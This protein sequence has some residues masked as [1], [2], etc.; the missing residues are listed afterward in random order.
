[1]RIADVARFSSDPAFLVLRNRRDTLNDRIDVNR[2]ALVTLPQGVPGGDA[3]RAELTTQLEGGAREL[4][5]VEDQLLLRYPRFMELT[6]PRPVT[7]EDLQQKLL[8][9][10]EALLTYV[11]LPQETVIFAVTR[12]RFK[13]VSSGVRRDDL[14]RRIHGIRRSIEK[15][16]SGDSVLFLRE[17]DPATLHSLH[18][19]LIDP[20]SDLLAGVEKVIVVGDGPLHTIPLEFFVTR[21][22]PAEQQA[23]RNARSAADGSNAHPYLGEYKL[24]EYLGKQFRFAYLPSL[25]A[26]TSQRLYPKATG[27]RSREFIAFADPDF[28]PVQGSDKQFSASTKVSLAAL[29]SSVPRLRDGT[30]A[31]PRL[32][33]TADEAREIAKLLGG[34]SE[35][36]IGSNAQEKTAKLGELKTARF[37]LFATHGFLG[38]EYLP[39]GLALTEAGGNVPASA[40]SSA[41]SEHQVIAQPALALSLVGDLSGEDGLLTM[42]EVIEDIE[43]NADVVALSACNTAGETVQA[44]NGEGF[45]GLTRAFMYA[46]AKSLIVSHWSVDSLSTQALMTNMFRNIQQGEPTL[47]AMSGA[48]RGMLGSEYASGNFHFSRSHPFFWAPFVYVGD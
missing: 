5:V 45:A 15:V 23:F 36:Y 27:T 14:A 35:L 33:E 48:Q 37:V 13:M 20:V 31:I 1:M 4:R 7:V 26:L 16:T 41:G 28:S 11:L 34:A 24:P 3:R 22:T 25:S 10:G 42:K 30:P 38:G 44:N 43:L 8:K 12:E 32:R 17:I 21:W 46:G 6:N 47:T 2:Q 9:P 19:D 18:R 40:L 29:G 39:A